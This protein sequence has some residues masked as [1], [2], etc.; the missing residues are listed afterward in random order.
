[1]ALLI[2]RGLDW[3]QMQQHVSSAAPEEA[4]GLVAGKGK[5]SRMVFAVENVLHSPTNFLMEA[6]GQVRAFLMIEELGYDLLAIYHSHPNGP[7]YLSPTDLAEHAYPE[8]AVL[9]WYPDVGGWACRGFWLAEGSTK[10]IKVQIEDDTR[11][12]STLD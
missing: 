9:I 4:C 5:I 7:E 2:L 3:A 12:T 11:N 1:M 8:T 10:P 6:E